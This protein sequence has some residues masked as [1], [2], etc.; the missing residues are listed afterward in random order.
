MVT[1]PSSFAAVAAKGVQ[2]R[3]Q[4][5]FL[6]RTCATKFTW[7]DILRKITDWLPLE[8]EEEMFNN[9]ASGAVFRAEY[10]LGE[11][12]QKDYGLE[13]GKGTFTSYIER[14]D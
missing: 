12:K 13:K 9:R 14:L 7:D 5:T 10:L 8:N 6:H 2:P 3:T 1:G 11:G 4:P